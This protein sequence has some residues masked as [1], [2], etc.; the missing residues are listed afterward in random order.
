MIESD[1][2]HKT[3]RKICTRW[4]H[5]LNA[6]ILIIG[7]IQNLSICTWGQMPYTY[8]VFIIIPHY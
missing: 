2:L 1:V 4:W 7:S 3:D 8:T 6:Y 5:A